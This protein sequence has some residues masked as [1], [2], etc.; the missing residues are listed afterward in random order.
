MIKK[1][2]RKFDT[3]KRHK[4]IRVNLNGT[5]ER[6]R[7]AVFRSNKHIYAQVIDDTAGKTLIS[8]GTVEKELKEK[9]SHGGNIDASKEVGKLI[10][11]RAKQ[12]GIKKVIFDRGGNLYHGRV[13]QLADAVRE[14]GLE[15]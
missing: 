3:Q 7:L 4:K 10:A 11:E 12:K 5:E 14:G 2:I 6:P 8:A 1:K 13:A 15:F 9:L